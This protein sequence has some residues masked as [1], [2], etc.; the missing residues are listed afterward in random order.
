MQ[1]AIHCHKLANFFS[2][3]TIL[4]AL[5]TVKIQKLGG[6]SLVPRASKLA[7]RKLLPI[8]SPH[9]NMQVCE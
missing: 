3:F 4:G 5:Q 8:V 9:R 2:L 7:L 6:W 1:T